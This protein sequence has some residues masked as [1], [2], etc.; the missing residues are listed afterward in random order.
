MPMNNASNQYQISRYIVDAAGNTPYATIQSAIDAANAAGVLATVYI[1]PGAYTENL[2][3]YSNVNLE[4]AG[5]TPATTVSLTGVHT[6][7][8]AGNV[9]FS[10]IKFISA[11]DVLNSAAAGTTG[12]VFDKCNFNLT[13]GFVFNLTNWTGGLELVQCGEESTINGIVSNAGGS[14]VTI[15]YSGVGVGATT[16]VTSGTTTVNCS[17]IYIPVSISGATTLT[18]YHSVFKGTITT[19]NTVAASFD[20][21]AILTGA[22]LAINAL[23]TSTVILANVVVDSSNVPVITGAA[24]AA[25]TFGE[26]TYTTNSGVTTVGRTYTTRLETGEIQLDTTD[27]GCMYLNAGLVTPAAMTNGQLL[28]GSTGLVPVVTTLTAGTNVGVTNAAGSITINATGHAAFTW[29]TIGADGPLTAGNGYINTKVAA[30]SVS[31]PATSA[32]GTVIILQGVGA[33]GWTI[34]QGAGQQIV[35]GASATTGGAGGSLASTNAN[36]SVSMV[37]TTADTVWHV[38]AMIGNL[39]VV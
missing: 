19:N 21:C 12:L 35:V 31:L 20:N 5:I 15:S 34:T 29:S 32:V 10:K 22:T 8:A 17:R 39:T 23:D 13:N 1:R 7:P 2:T 33:G 28:V 36:D 3:L 26:V 30:L 27:T 37:C 14:A 24:G 9:R 18:A 25:V 11:T 38:F 6:P 16:M 4:G